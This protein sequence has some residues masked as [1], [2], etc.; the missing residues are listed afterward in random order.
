MRP[1]P[2]LTRRGLEDGVVALIGVRDGQRPELEA[3]FFDPLG[4]QAVEIQR[5]SDLRH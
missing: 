5:E 1:Q 4:I 2:E 3:G